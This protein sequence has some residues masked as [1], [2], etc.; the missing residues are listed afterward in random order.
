MMMGKKEGLGQLI[1]KIIDALDNESYSII[2]QPYSDKISISKFELVKLD[3]DV[4][5]K[6]REQS[7]ELID[8][9]IYRLNKLNVGSAHIKRLKELN[10][11]SRKT[12][13]NTKSDGEKIKR[14][15]D[16]IIMKLKEKDKGDSE[17]DMCN[18][19]YFSEKGCDY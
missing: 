2:K 1:D 18:L 19:G 13:E 9:I 16:E 8:F 6:H 14:E 10:E 15:V 7:I 17:V 12:L 5:I 4:N 11:K 3:I